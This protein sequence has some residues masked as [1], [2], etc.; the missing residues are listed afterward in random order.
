MHCSIHIVCICHKP[1][2]CFCCCSPPLVA[3]SVADL[4]AVASRLRTYISGRLFLK[5]P[6]G[7]TLKRVDDSDTIR[8]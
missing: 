4:R 2:C 1:C 7:R 5:E 3:V 6:E 8:A